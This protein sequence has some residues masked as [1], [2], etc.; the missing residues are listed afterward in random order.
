MLPF[1]SCLTPP[2]TTKAEYVADLLTKR[3]ELMRDVLREP[4]EEKRKVMFH[5]I[6]DYSR[7]I[8]KICDLPYK[9]R[10]EKSKN[11]TGIYWHIFAIFC[12]VC[13]MFLVVAAIIILI[14]NQA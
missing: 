14:V 8:A 10:K 6:E 2:N 9:F 4:D 7:K 3:D 12:M 5:E 13:A 1:T 11:D